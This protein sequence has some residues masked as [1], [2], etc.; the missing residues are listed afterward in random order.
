MSD[1]A[2]PAEPDSFTLR[3]GHDELVIR[4]RYEVLSIVNDILIG[5]WFV[6]GSVFFFY[7]SLTTVGTGLFVAGSVELLIRPMIRLARHVHL[8]KVDTAS[9]V[10]TPHDF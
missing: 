7:E 2:G 9:S 5:V 4:K 3:I 1:A 6:I 10:E 8:Q